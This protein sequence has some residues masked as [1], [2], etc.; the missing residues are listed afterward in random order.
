LSRLRLLQEDGRVYRGF[1]SRGSY[2]ASFFE[3]VIGDVTVW[4]GLTSTPMINLHTGDA[5]VPIRDYSTFESENE[6]LIAG[7]SGF[8]V[9]SVHFIDVEGRELNS[10]SIMPFPIVALR[11][12]LH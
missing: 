9:E 8:R 10:S 12:F 11:D 6:V 1:R 5:G 2:V 4:P 3:S 7:S